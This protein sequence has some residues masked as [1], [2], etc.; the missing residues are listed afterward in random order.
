MACIIFQET[1]A[2]IGRQRDEF[3]VRGSHANGEDLQSVLGRSLCRRHRVAFEILSIGHQDHD[4]VAAR[5]ALQ[6]GVRLL[7]G[8]RDVGAAAG[9][10]VGIER[11][12]GFVKSAVIKRDRGLQKGASGEGHESDG[13]AVQV[14]DEIIDG[15]FGAREPVRLDV[16]RQHAARS[17]YGEDDVMAAPFDLFPAESRL[18]LSKSHAQQHYGCGKQYTLGHD[19]CMGDGPRE[20]FPQMNATRIAPAR[21]AD[22]HR[23]GARAS[24]EP[25]NATSAAGNHTGCAKI[26]GASGI[27]CSPEQNS[28]PARRSREIMPNETAPDNARIAAPPGLSFRAD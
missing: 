23:S 7:D 3:A 24:T 15:E 25:P 18:R 5:T 26:M 12:Q 9:N 11:A 19:A 27:E 2:L 8:A 22:G 28:S 6:R 20:I 1:T 13:I 4:L 10:D 16:R 21:P 14:A 17:V